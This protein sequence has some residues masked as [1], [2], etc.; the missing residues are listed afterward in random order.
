MPVKTKIEIKNY[1]IFIGGYIMHDNKKKY[2]KQK[3][4]NMIVKLK[5]E[6]SQKLLCYKSMK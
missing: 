5:N 2:L 6:K 1:Y 3:K 4:Q